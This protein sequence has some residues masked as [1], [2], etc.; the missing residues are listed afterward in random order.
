VIKEKY[1][2]LGAKIGH[3][4]DNIS[5]SRKKFLPHLAWVSAVCVNSEDLYVIFLSTCF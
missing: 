1:P 3:D 2:E 4:I 5:T